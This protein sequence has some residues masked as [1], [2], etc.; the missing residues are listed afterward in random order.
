MTE[1]EKTMLALAGVNQTNFITIPVSTLES[2]GVPLGSGKCVAVVL[3]VNLYDRNTQTLV[4]GDG[5]A[6]FYI[7]D[8][9]RQEYEVVFGINSQVIFCSDLSE[10]W[11]RC[12][13]LE[14]ETDIINVQAIVYTQS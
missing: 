14:K 3:R 6:Q 2:E 13:P 1:Q 7:G 4:G 9:N 8:A 5:G 11:V 10:V 12:C